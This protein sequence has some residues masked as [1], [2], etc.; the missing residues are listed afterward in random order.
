MSVDNLGLKSKV[1][2]FTL[3]LSILPVPPPDSL[4]DQVL[5]SVSPVVSP[6]QSV[7]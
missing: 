4:Q 3:P 2:C 1:F 6:L 5:A 7:P